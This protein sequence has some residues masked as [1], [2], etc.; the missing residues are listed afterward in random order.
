MPR[1][2]TDLSDQIEAIIQQATARIVAL[3][4]GER[5][6]MLESVQRAVSALDSTLKERPSL[7]EALR[8]AVPASAL[9]SAQAKRPPRDQW[10]RTADVVTRLRD[11]LAK[12]RNGARIAELREETQF[13]D[14]QLHRALRQLRD[15]GEVTKEGELRRT[16]YR[17]TGRKRPTPARK[18]A[19][20]KRRTA[21]KKTATKKTATKK[22]ATAKKR[23]TTKKTA[24]K[25]RATAKKRATTKK[26]ATK[27]RA[28][29]KKTATKKTAAKKTATKKTAT[30]KT[31][32]RSISAK[33]HGRPRR[34][35][36]PPHSQW[37]STDDVKRAARKALR[38]QSNG[39]RMSDLCAATGYSD[40]QIYRA[41]VAL[42][43]EGVVQRVGR[44]RNMR[45]VIA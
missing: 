7:T 34:S 43:D 42:V 38:K 27:K 6:A 1:S 40:K 44:L 8:S 35:A 29:A 20:A 3:L 14:M 9:R 5:E 33:N 39:L 10:V 45:Y 24:T 17:Y 15:D 2:K 22:R 4:D 23:A 30:R 32:G 25:K 31:A 41:I 28:T 19:T 37:V 21:G 12:R 11:L 13:S 26:T 16:V 36:R 18:S